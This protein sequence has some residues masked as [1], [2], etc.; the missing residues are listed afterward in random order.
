MIEL[1]STSTLLL[2]FISLLLLCILLAVCLKLFRYRKQLKKK[3]MLAGVV[4]IPLFSTLFF[5]VATNTI[6]IISTPSAQYTVIKG[7]LISTSVKD[8]R[9]QVDQAFLTVTLADQFG[10]E[11]Q[12][13]VSD[14]LN[15]FSYTYT[16][17]EP[18]L[19]TTV[20]KVYQVTLLDDMILKVESA[21]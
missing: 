11:K 1:Y 15:P 2:S 3:D 4:F 9:N 18:S 10:E 8:G 6:K 17:N 7:T 14:I 21:N 12:I 20:G 13:K 5:M 19:F 16:R